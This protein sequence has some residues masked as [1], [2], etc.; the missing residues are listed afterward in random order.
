MSNKMINHSCFY[1]ISRNTKEMHGI[2]SYTTLNIQHEPTEANFD[3]T[4]CTW[5][6][7][8]VSVFAICLL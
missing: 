2:Y 6:I 7:E 3:R 8:F 1:A 5:S 4:S